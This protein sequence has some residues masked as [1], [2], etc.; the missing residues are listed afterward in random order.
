MLLSNRSSPHLSF[1]LV[2]NTELP[3]H[4]PPKDAPKWNMHPKVF[5]SFSD[6]GKA[7]CPYCGAK[8]E[9]EK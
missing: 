9:L 1:R 6:N 4:C 2:M 5:L 3:F 8:Y 7:S